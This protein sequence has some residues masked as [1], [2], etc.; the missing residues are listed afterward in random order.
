M[1]GVRPSSQLHGFS[2]LDSVVWRE[3]GKQAGGEGEREEGGRAERGRADEESIS[4][5]M[6]K[7]MDGLMAG[8]WRDG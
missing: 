7:E 1:N 5:E 4:K 8:W 2:I 6:D 3:K